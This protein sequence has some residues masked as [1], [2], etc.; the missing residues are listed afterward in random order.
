MPFQKVSAFSL[1]IRF[2]EDCSWGL[3][4]DASERFNVLQLVHVCC[5]ES[6]AS[7]GGGGMREPTAGILIVTM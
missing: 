4:R 3:G 7:S 2:W 1:S 6:E 5:V